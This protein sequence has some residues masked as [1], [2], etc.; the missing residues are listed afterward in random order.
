M[1]KIIAVLCLLIVIQSIGYTQDPNAE[2]EAKKRELDTTRQDTSRVLL[3]VDLANLYNLISPDSA[4]FYGYKALALARQINFPKGEVGALTY[5][6]WTHL[7]IGNYSEALQITLKGL[8]IAERSNLVNDKAQFLTTLGWIYGGIEDHRK[9]LDLYREAKVL[10]DSLHNLPLSTALQIHIAQTYLMMNQSDSALY[11]S[12]S[13]HEKAVQLNIDWLKLM[14]LWTLGRVQGK[15][16]NHDLALAYVRQ[17]L[18][19][20]VTPPVH[21]SQSYFYIAELYQQINK[22]DSC[23]YYANKSLEAGRGFYPN[24]IEANV[25]L[26]RMYEKRDPQKALDYSRTAILYKD[27]L[28]NLAKTISVK[29]LVAFDDQERQY[30]IETA[31]TAY[32]NQMR[33]YVLVAGLFV[34]LLI[35]FILYRNNRHRKKAYARLQKQKQETEAQKTK[36][37]QALAELKTTQA[38]LVQREKMASLGELTA[39][40]AHEIQNPLNF[41]NNFS[42]VNGELIQELKNEAAK[43]NLAEVAVLANDIEVNSEKINHHG[44]RADGIVKG[45]L[46]HS[47]SSSGQNEPTDINTLCDEYLRLAYHGFR[48]KG[49]SFNATL[50]TNF[51]DSIRKINIIPQD[52]GRVLLNLYNN[53]FYAVSEKKK[54]HVE[55]Y[56]PAVSVSTKKINNKI[57]IRVKDN[58]NGISQKVTDKIFQPFFTTKPTGQGTGLGLSLS[59]DIIKAHGGDI[60]VETKEGEGSEFKIDLPV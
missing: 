8:K 34:F 18:V 9:A 53:A 37:E 5:I 59:Y 12:Q 43:G 58:G 30:E 16:G 27:S 17:S 6:A 46:Q 7:R 35:A 50:Q 49:K 4:F 1:K 60:K 52:I 25:L 47:S 28:Y 48:A 3:M 2:A 39:G 33:Q 32:R 10:M 26:S 29:N 45:M 15:K 42:E 56:E 55:N 21:F 22:Q 23:I 24:M 19:F 11:Y 41:V 31:K 20:P 40:I 36:A 38:Q 51:D 44:R 13:A 57:E 14:T 54:Q